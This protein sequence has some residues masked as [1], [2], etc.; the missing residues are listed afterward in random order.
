MMR[1]VASDN[2][3]ESAHGEGF[4]V[5]DTVTGPCAGRQILEQANGREANEAELFDVI[6]PRNSLGLG[7]FR[8]D[9]LVVAGKG[10]L[11]TS[12]KPEGA[13][14][15]GAFGVR[16]VIENIANAPF[17]GGVAVKRRFLRDAGKKFEGIGQLFLHRGERVIA[18]YLIDVCEIV[19]SGFG[20]FRAAKHAGNVSQVGAA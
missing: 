7:A 17:I 15:E 10:R 2:E 1:D 3:S 18:G 13:K 8:A 5:G 14:C 11:E 9:I 19:G 6:E 20:I 4:A 12:R 16:D